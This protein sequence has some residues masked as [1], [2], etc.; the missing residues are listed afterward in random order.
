MSASAVSDIVSSL[1]ALGA[2]AHPGD[3]FTVVSW[4]GWE[5]YALP[6]MLGVR[7]GRSG[8][9]GVYVCKQLPCYAED[10]ELRHFPDSAVA[11]AVEHASNMLRLIERAPTAP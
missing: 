10:V 9:G 2:L 6:R 8:A 5:H 4:P 3:G 1:C 11:E 7:I